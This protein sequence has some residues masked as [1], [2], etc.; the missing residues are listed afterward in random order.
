MFEKLGIRIVTSLIIMWYIIKL[1]I[2][3]IEVDF[4]VFMM[5]LLCACAMAL[6]IEVGYELLR[7]WIRF[8]FIIFMAMSIF[9]FLIYHYLGMGMYLGISLYIFISIIIDLYRE[10]RMTKL[11]NQALNHHFQE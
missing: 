2:L 5:M 11:L 7:R 9:S 10:Y 8:V 4:Y 3:R 1:S 6:L